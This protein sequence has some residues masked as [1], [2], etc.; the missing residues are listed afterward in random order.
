MNENC[1]CDIPKRHVPDKVDVSL[2]DDYESARLVLAFDSVKRKINF[3]LPVG[4]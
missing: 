4:R 1:R 2:E 3:S